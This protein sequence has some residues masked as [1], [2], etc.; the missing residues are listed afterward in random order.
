MNV[1]IT[2]F[3]NSDLE[4]VATMTNKRCSS[5][6]S[7]W[8]LTVSVTLCISLEAARSRADYVYGGTQLSW[9]WLTDASR[10]IVVGKVDSCDK[11]GKFTLRVERVLKRNGVEVEPGQVVGGPILGRTSLYN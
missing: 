3:P 5:F 2:R 6:S 1:R 7:I 9:Q 8:A 4:Y 10:A 11:A